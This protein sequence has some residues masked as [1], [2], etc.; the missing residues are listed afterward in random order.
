MASDKPSAV[1][2][3]ATAEANAT[4]STEPRELAP[5]TIATAAT[6]TLT[7]CQTLRAAKRSAA[8][9]RLAARL[10][11]SV[12]P[13]MAQTAHNMAR[14]TPMAAASRAPHTTTTQ[15]LSTASAAASE[16]LFTRSG[17]ILARS[18]APRNT[19]LEVSPRLDNWAM[20]AAAVVTAKYCPRPLG[21]S[22]RAV[23][24]PVTRPPARTHRRD[25][26]VPEMLLPRSV[27]SAVT[28][29]P[30]GSGPWWRGWGWYLLVR[31]TKARARVAPQ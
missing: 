16:A 25:A 30:R 10:H 6:S 24:M 11:S 14:G 23:T 2:V 4:C 22:A 27:V 17:R 5:A 18:R 26:I 8:T 19:L 20:I 21:P 12:A 31:A 1:A 7:T 9:S 15:A 3:A 28:A 13:P 29:A